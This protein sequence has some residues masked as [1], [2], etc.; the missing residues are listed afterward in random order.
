MY[1]IGIDLG[2]KGEHKAA[3]CNEKGDYVSR[4]ISFRST[5]EGIDNLIAAARK[6]NPEEALQAIMEP[7]G[8]AWYPVAVMLENRGV[9][10]YLVNS[11]QVAD[12]RKYLKKHAK[13]DRVDVRVLT[14]LPLINKEQLH[15]LELPG[16]VALACQRGC[17]MY[18]RL[19]IEQTAIKNRILAIDLFAWPGLD[20][21]KV[22]PDVF[23]AAALWFRR[24]Y[25]SPYQVKRSGANVIHQKWLESPEYDGKTG[26]WAVALE[27]LA[28]QVTTIYGEEGEAVDYS[29]LQMEVTLE[30]NILDMVSATR[31]MVQSKIVQPLYRK[32]HPKRYLETIPGVGKEGAAVYASIIGHPG[33]FQN[34]RKHRGWSGMVPNSR[35]SSTYLG[36]GLKIT[37]AGPRLIRKFA[38]LDAEI[39]RQ[40]DP[41]IAAIYYDQMVNKG[42]HHTQAVCVCATH[43]LDR[44]LTVL[45]QNRPYILKDTQ[46]R[47][48]SQEE[49]LLIISE[50]FKVPADVRL[51]NK[52]HARAERRDRLAEKFIAVEGKSS[53]VASEKRT[54]LE[55]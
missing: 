40:R 41:Q 43:L 5:T 54:D 37:Q 14:R 49:A 47:P 10:N 34:S 11:Q 33:R 15:R 30:E 42:K 50:N 27:L 39:A 53:R 23:G 25:Y 13:S 16:A 24:N 36:S 46:G 18:D 35:Q 1:T 12:L 28:N 8:M 9:V 4:I 2:V 21:A 22:F 51:R 52:K 45:K 19:T 48:V 31:R 26:N 55:N 32:I 20:R 17:K 29:L 44:V 38:Y 7:T 6:Q 3:I